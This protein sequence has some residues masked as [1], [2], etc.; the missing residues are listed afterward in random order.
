[1][2]DCDRASRG[3][4]QQPLLAMACALPDEAETTAATLDFLISIF[5]VTIL[6]W[7]NILRI[8]SIALPN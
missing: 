5:A 2:A 1:V 3:I 8:C 7:L 6:Q 4:V